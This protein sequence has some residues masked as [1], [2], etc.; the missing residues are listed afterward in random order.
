M[1]KNEIYGT[2]GNILE[3][4]RILIGVTGSI[5][6][7]EIPHLVREIL[8]HSGEPIVVLS[9][10]ALRFVTT[11]AITWSMGSTPYT[12]I[13]GFSE[14]IMWSV[15]PDHRVDLYLLCPATANTISKLAN[16][17]AD[18]PVTLSALACIGANIPCLIVPAAHSV[19][20]DNPITQKSMQY[21][22]QVNVQFLSSEEEENKHKFPSLSRLMDKIFDLTGFNRSL[23]GKK[24]II[25][26]GATREYL[27][28]VRFI[29][30]ASSGLSALY[31]SQSLKNLG[32]S[33][34]LVL[35]EGNTLSLNNID[36]PVTLVRSA[37]DM[38]KE[39][40]N[41]FLDNSCDGLVAVAAVADYQPEFQ[42]GKIPSRQEQLTMNLKPTIKIVDSI[43][44]EFPSIYTVTYKAEVGL[45]ED[46]L[47]E[48]G[49]QFLE[50][51]NVDVVCANWV[52]ESDKGFV[53]KTNEIFVIRKNH[54]PLHLTGS[55]K[56]IG[57]KI[58]A[59][60]S[61]EFTKRRMV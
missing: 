21:L 44:K 55:K 57:E 5:A 35:G 41:Q 22:N 15:N 30:N 17:V 24:F 11:D 37:S 59:V 47:V 8:R 10:E 2:K 46:A 9:E 18:G 12:K 4:K 20:L 25:T 14:H 45:T 40:R 48:R 38:Y 58:A 1:S 23:E 3:G 60:I 54:D 34:S 50:A 43:K 26:G 28:D 56:A 61:E 39:V 7:I 52:G 27:D 33:V 29:S 32:A 19:L 6:A 31:V 53:T 42:S 51:N 49:I 16:G 13:S 36:I